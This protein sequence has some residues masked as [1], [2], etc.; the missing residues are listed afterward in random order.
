M[1]VARV[2]GRIQA[3]DVNPIASEGDT[4]L[5][6]VPRSAVGRVT[7]Q[8]WVEDEA[9]NIGYRAALLTIE[10]GTIKCIEWLETGDITS[11][12]IERPS[13]IDLGGHAEIAEIL[14]PEIKD[15]STRP[16]CAELPHIC[17][18]MEA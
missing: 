4:W 1:T 7:A 16:T 8:F 10:H 17:P 12:P 6:Q 15:I 3:Q 18:K 14:H 11:L 13:I 2:W 5:F 9:G